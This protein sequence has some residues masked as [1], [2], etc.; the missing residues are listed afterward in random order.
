MLD[1]KVILLDASS[2][3]S[4]LLNKSEKLTEAQNLIIV[5]LKIRPGSEGLSR[6]APS[7]ASP[8]SHCLS[9]EQVELD[10]V[11]M[12]IQG[13]YPYQLNPTT[14]LGSSQAGRSHYPLTVTIVII[15]TIVTI[16]NSNNSYYNPLYAHQRN[17]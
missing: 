12:T 8:C 9:F 17:E 11:V 5:S 10:C 7:D 16:V 13:P 4:M 14:Y 6:L 15:I 1:A 2:K 3:M